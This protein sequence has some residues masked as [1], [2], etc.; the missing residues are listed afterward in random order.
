MSAFGKVGRVGGV[1]L[2][3][4]LEEEWVGSL[5]AAGVFEVDAVVAQ[6]D[7]AGADDLEG[8]VD[9]LILREEVAALGLQRAGVGRERGEDGFFFFGA[10]WREQWRVGAEEARV[11]GG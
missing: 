6:A 4:D 11:L 7:G 5:L 1:G 3:F 8:D 2:L 10:K 9:R